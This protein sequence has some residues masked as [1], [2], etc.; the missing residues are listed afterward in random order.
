MLPFLNN[1]I[2]DDDILMPL[3]KHLIN[4]KA[5]TDS[6]LI[7]STKLQIK[8]NALD[9]NKSFIFDLEPGVLFILNNRTFKI[10]N[11]RR[12]RYECLEINTNKKFLVKGNAPVEIVSH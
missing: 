12:T 2:F 4:A 5:T 3:A 6:D 7:L 11:K 8:N 10:L 9:S 1:T